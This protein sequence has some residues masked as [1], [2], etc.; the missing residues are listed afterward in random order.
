MNYLRKN[1]L[2]C[3]AIIQSTKKVTYEQLINK[4]ENLRNKTIAEA[5]CILFE[6][7]P[8]EKERFALWEI[9]KDKDSFYAHHRQEYTKKFFSEQLDTIEIFESSEKVSI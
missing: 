6:I 2:Y 1:Y 3:T 7:M 4:L 5:G 8:L 9:W